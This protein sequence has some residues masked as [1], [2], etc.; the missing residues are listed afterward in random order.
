GVRPEEAEQFARWLGGGYRLPTEAEWRTADHIL[1]KI[2]LEHEALL[3]LGR[4]PRIHPAAR[5]ILNW[6]L[7][8]LTAA[9]WGAAALLEGGLWGGVRLSSPGYGLQGRPPASLLQIIH[10]PQIHPAVEPTS[11]ARHPAFGFRLVRPRP[12]SPVVS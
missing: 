1:G 2:R 5:A 6:N 4:N 3:G 7:N 10:N 12:P 8:R 9:T 11:T